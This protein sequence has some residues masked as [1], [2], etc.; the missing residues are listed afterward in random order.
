MNKISYIGIKETRKAF[1]IVNRALL[2]QELTELPEGRYRLTVEKYKKAKSNPQLG[3]LYKV[4]YPLSMKFLNEA[5][6][7]ITSIEAVDLFWKEQFATQE[8]INRNTGEIR[9]IPALK[10]DFLTID[11]LT[12]IDSIRN[13]CAEFLGGYIPEPLENMTIEFK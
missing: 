2:D 3:Y 5:G 10:R 4:V 8:V 11:M 1:R 12:Y 6:W 7:E 13:Y 9:H